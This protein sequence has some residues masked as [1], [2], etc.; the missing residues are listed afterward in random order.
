MDA[1]GARESAVLYAL[2]ITR[3]EHAENRFYKSLKTVRAAKQF[4]MESENFF[5]SHV[6]FCQ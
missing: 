2:R 3:A 1:A 6:P 4:G 5:F